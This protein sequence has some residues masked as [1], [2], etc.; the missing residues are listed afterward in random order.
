ME[1]QLSGPS[2]ACRRS[3]KHIVVNDFTPPSQRPIRVLLTGDHEVV[4]AGLRLLLDRDARFSLLAEQ[5]YATGCGADVVVLDLDGDSKNRLISFSPLLLGTTRLLLLTGD[6]NQS[7]VATALRHGATGVVAKQDTPDVLLKAIQKVHCGEVW[8]D[9]AMVAKAL[10]ELIKGAGTSR[11]QS[12]NATALSP[13]ELQ[14]TSLVS[15][16]HRNLN[17]ADRL[18]ISEITVRNHLTSIFRK[19]DVSS[20]LQLTLYA[21]RHGM[22]RLPN[23]FAAAPLYVSATGATRRKRR[24]A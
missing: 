17:I 23:K 2:S 1:R 21:F 22:T 12:D 6:L 13:R 24:P 7:T 11:G 20:R 16:G 4:L 3:R 15:E 5:E 14:V 19:L 18:C 9:R 10:S 8:L